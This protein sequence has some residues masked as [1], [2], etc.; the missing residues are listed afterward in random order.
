MARSPVRIDT[1]YATAASIASW[2]APAKRRSIR[3]CL[4]LRIVAH[5]KGCT[6]HGKQLRRR[7]RGRIECPV[8][9][10]ETSYSHRLL[11]SHLSPQSFDRYMQAIFKVV[12]AEALAASLPASMPH[13]SSEWIE[14]LRKHVVEEILTLK[15]QACGQAFVDF[16][17]CFALRCSRCLAGL[18]AWCGRSCENQTVAHGHVVACPFAPRQNQLYG[19]QALPKHVVEQVRIRMKHRT[20]YY[21][22][23]TNLFLLSIDL[24]IYFYIYLVILCCHNVTGYGYVHPFSIHF[25][26]APSNSGLLLR[27]SKPGAVRTGDARAAGRA[28]TALPGRGGEADSTPGPL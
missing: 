8:Q 14:L 7:R 15:C 2:L 18:C 26:W 5:R 16:D 10:C 23:L 3:S 19:T 25:H 17:G 20:Y 11:A 4:E 1:S 12:E 27:L 9:P 13:S 6:A 28:T 24:S 21:Y 22:L